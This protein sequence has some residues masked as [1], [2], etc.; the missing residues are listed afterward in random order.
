MKKKKKIEKNKKKNIK[1]H[2][3]VNIIVDK[4]SK[5]KKKINNTEKN[6]NNENKKKY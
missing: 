1:P 3:T 4:I 2:H 6:R 5:I